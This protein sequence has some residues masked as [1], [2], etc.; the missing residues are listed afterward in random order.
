MKTVQKRWFHATTKENWGKIKKEGI[1]WGIDTWERRTFLAAN[2]KQLIW[3]MT[4]IFPCNTD[5]QNFD[6]IL[7]VR[8]IPNNIDD[9]WQNHWELVVKKPIPLENVRLLRYI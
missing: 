5:M 6:L 2:L 3:F 7:S 9:I 8:Y 4:H 1:L